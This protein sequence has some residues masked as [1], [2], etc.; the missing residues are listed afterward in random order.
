MGASGI[1]LPKKRQRG[2][3]LKADEEATAFV[4]SFKKK[5]GQKPS[6]EDVLQ[7]LE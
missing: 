6:Y 7:M 1:E 2:V 3:D 5:V 4:K